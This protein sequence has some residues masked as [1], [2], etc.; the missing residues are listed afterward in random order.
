M[1]GKRNL[2]ADYPSFDMD[3]D[4]DFNTDISSE[5]NQE[6]TEP[7]KRSVVSN[8]V[9]GALQ[10]TKDTLTSPQFIHQ[11]LKKALPNAYGEITESLG[12][13]SQGSYELYDETV[14]EL[15]PRVN[16]IMTKI[17][18]MVPETQKGLKSITKKIV[19]RTGTSTYA[20]YDNRANQ[21]EQTVNQISQWS[22][23]S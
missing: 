20:D 5:V 17:D 10:G 12:E 3:L 22:M 11:T 2:E 8:V 15:K 1:A 7:K 21:E 6:A 13:V 18:S 4:L 14:R 23:I 19:E 9:K 16:R